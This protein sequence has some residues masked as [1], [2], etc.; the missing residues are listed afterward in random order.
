MDL[1]VWGK[2]GLQ[3]EFHNSYGYKEKPCLEKPKRN[4]KVN[5]SHNQSAY[6]VKAPLMRAVLLWSTGTT[7]ALRAMLLR[8]SPRLCHLSNHRFLASLTM[9]S[10]HSALWLCCKTWALGSCSWYPVPASN[11]PYHHRL[12][13]SRTI[14]PN[15]AIFVFCCCVFVAL[16]YF[17]HV[18][19]VLQNKQ[20]RKSLLQAKAKL[21]QSV[22]LTWT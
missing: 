14:N 1:W 10:V 20:T 11:S 8:R 3:T 2:P 4:K 18:I 6:T 21:L 13:S 9:S 15:K 16:L 17:G 22:F 7:V 19:L 12:W 5:K